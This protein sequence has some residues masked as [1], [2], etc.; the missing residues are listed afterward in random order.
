MIFAGGAI[1]EIT[2][3]LFTLWF[4]LW[5]VPFYCD[6]GCRWRGLRRCLPWE[7]QPLVP[8]PKYESSIA[9]FRHRRRSYNDYGKGR[10]HFVLRFLYAFMEFG[11]HQS[12]NIFWS[13]Q[14]FFLNT[15]ARLFFNF[16]NLTVQAWRPWRD[17]AINC[18][19]LAVPNWHNQTPRFLT[20]SRGPYL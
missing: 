1:K 17:N 4:L 5:T 16:H 10:I 20:W 14:I 11:I 12:L 2:C 6:S 7:R 13:C 8:A 9:S 3:S 19:Y 15:R 18:R